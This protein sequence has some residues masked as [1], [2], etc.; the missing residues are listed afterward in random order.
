MR[1]ANLVTTDELITFAMKK[2][3]DKKK[4]RDQAWNKM[5]NELDIDYVA[6]FECGGLDYD[7]KSAQEE[8]AD[9]AMEK[10]TSSILFYETI[11]AFMR[12]HRITEFKLMAETN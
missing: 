1:K 9:A 10:E 11:I 3:H 2:R 7:M 8:L 6:L 12:Q 5:V 4:W